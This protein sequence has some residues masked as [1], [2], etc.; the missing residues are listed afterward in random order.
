MTL[1]TDDRGIVIAC[2]HCGQKNRLAYA[3]REFRRIVLERLR[4]ITATE[5]EFRAEARVLLGTDEFR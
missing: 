4:E 2:G 5:E 1:E 3:R